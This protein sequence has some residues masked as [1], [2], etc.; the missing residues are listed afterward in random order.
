MIDQESGSILVPVIQ[1]SVIEKTTNNPC[2]DLPTCD[3]ACQDTIRLF[4]AE[5]VNLKPHSKNIEIVS[6]SSMLGGQQNKGKGASYAANSLT[7]LKTGLTGSS[8]VLQ[9]KAK[10]KMVKPKKTRDWRLENC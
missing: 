3:V 8:G 7:G 6:S 5:V 4:Q 9:N 10:S 1:E 2:K